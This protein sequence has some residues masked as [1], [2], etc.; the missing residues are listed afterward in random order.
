MM[1]PV[2]TGPVPFQNSGA[3][4]E[5]PLADDLHCRRISTLCS[6]L[7]CVSRGLLLGS[8]ADFPAFHRFRASS[9]AFFTLS[10]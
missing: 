2:K 4:H 5:V 8:G 7:T 10:Y 9:T 6:S 3:R 1:S